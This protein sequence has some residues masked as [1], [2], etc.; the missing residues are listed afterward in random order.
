MQI[1]QMHT[2]TTLTMTLIS[3]V[4]A[5]LSGMWVWA[6]K[7]ADVRLSINDLYMALLMTGWM[8]LLQGIAM[9]HSTYTIMGTVLVVASLFV[10]RFQI[11]VSQDQYLQGMIPHH[12]M[13]VFLSKKQIEKSGN[14]EKILDGLPFSIIQSQ[15]VEIGKMKQMLN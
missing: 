9:K 13:A 1:M 3:I 2:M 5:L 10:I 15:R 6:D 14:N 8:F 7:W 11:L 4:A 12:S